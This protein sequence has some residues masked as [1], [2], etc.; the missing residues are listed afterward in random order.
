M[1]VGDIYGLFSREKSMWL[2]AFERGLLDKECAYR[3]M[4]YVDHMR[5]VTVEWAL[6]IEQLPCTERMALDMVQ[7]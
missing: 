7:A 4:D 6:F 3:L 1:S 2:D 5:G